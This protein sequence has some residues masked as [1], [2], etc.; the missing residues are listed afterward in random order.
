MRKYIWLNTV[1]II[2][3]AVLLVVSALHIATD[4]KGRGGR[5]TIIMG[6]RTVSFLNRRRKKRR[7]P[8]QVKPQHPMRNRGLSPYPSI[9]QLCKHSLPMWSGGSTVRTP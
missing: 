3:L 4:I 5:T 9:Y 1:L 6:C 7:N 8:F 2:A